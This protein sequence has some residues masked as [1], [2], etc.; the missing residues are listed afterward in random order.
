MGKAVRLAT[1]RPR[2]RLTVSSIGRAEL[3][4]YSK[5]V[6]QPMTFTGTCP[7]YDV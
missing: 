4:N 5:D 7:P 1:N 2:S 3:E 6:N